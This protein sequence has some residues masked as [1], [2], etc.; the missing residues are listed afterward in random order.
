[1]SQDFEQYRTAQAPVPS[2][3]WAWNLYGAGLENVGSDG[4]AEY[5]PLA[6]PGDDQLLVRVDAASLCFS[7][8]KVVRLGNQHPKLTDRDLKTQ[9][10]RLGHEATVTVVKV[11]A[12]FRDRY[13]PG[14]RLVIQPD[15]YHQG[16][17][18]AYGYSIPGA[19]TQY[20][21]MGAEVLDNEGVTYV[22]P[23][24]EEVGYAEAALTEPWACV[25]AAYTQRRRLAP[26]SGGI[27]WIAGRPGDTGSYQ[28]SQG[29]GA[30]ATIVLSDVPESVRALIDKHAMARL[31][32]RDGVS[33]QEFDVLKQEL[34][35][36]QGF[37]DIVLL[38]PRSAGLVG[39]AAKLLAR[40]GILNLVG[41]EPLDGNPVIDAGRIHYDY[42]AYLGNPGPDI[43]ASYGEA[44]N[45]AELSEG[46]VMLVAG[47]GGPM[48]QM[49]TQRAIEMAGGPKV[50]IA[51]DV[52]DERLALLQERF[53]PLAEQRGKRLIVFNPQRA[54][55]SLRD[56]VMR[57]TH[58]RGADDVIVCVPSGPLIGDVATL[59]APDGML[60]L[61]AGVA[62]GT[63]V[64]L[65]LTQVYLQNA[66]FTGTSGS[67]LTDQELVIRKTLD[68]EL[69]PSLAV[70]AVGGIESAQEGIRAVSE[71]RY[72]GKVVIFPQLN[73]LPLTAVTELEAKYPDIASKLAPDHVWTPQAEQALIERFL[74]DP[75][76]SQN[77]SGLPQR[78]VSKS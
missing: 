67:A 40:R 77:P 23:V 61:F 58:G 6:E 59:T 45:R 75:E 47:A 15:I 54:E 78:E 36:G 57:E 74:T 44:H 7:D 56:L 12:E 52:N 24:G 31:V 11:G 2:G 37:D 21:L 49:H 68:R 41:R 28:F 53:A 33:E 3:T 17:S 5:F 20:H 55:E 35:G 46:G 73:G 4:K 70:A 25:E 42:T 32:V 50:L 18:T 10:T 66:Q 48:G 63:M 60:V 76:R 69:S 9:P 8:V 13:H 72:P 34:T 65:D 39:E 19:L 27:M 14:E 29:L 30:P 26:K 38:E 71:G 51:T 62:I 1:L 16:K 64:P 43:A 22:F